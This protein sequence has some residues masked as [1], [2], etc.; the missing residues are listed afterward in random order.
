MGS[1]WTRDWTRVSCIGRWIL[2]HWAPRK[3][4]WLFSNL[5]SAV[6]SRFHGRVVG[7]RVQALHCKVCDWHIVLELLKIKM[8]E[9][10]S[11]LRITHSL[12][13]LLECYLQWQVFAGSTPTCVKSFF[14]PLLG[15]KTICFSNLYFPCRV[16]E[17]LDSV[18]T[19][20][21]IGH[22]NLSFEKQK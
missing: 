5:S 15:S 12:K 3:P 1:S 22:G 6:N 11:Y 18:L 14:S 13:V 8:L 21:A 19:S 2:Y 4:T 17:G 7:G 10:A 16:T 20:S 9:V